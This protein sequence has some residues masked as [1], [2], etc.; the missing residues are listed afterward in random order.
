MKNMGDSMTSVHKAIR[1]LREFSQNEPELGISQLSR[2]LGI[3]KS[4]VS[5]L[6]HILCAENMVVQNPE[7]RKYHLSLTA[8]EIGSVVYNEMELCQIA[9]PMLKK[10]LSTVQAAIQMVTYDNGGIIYLVKLPEH[11]DGKIL[12]VMGKRVPAHCTA[13]GKVMLAFQDEHE[14]NRV[15]SHNLKAFTHKTIT[16]PDKLRLELQTIRKR[17]YAVSHD[18]FNQGMSSVAVPVFN[19]YDAIIASICILRP[20]GQITDANIPPLL[21]EMKMYSRL[22]TEQLGVGQTKKLRNLH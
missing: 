4:T 6:I 9:F 12:N 21:K 22:I 5:R 20:T 15:M 13:S 2:R 10:M 18:E 17:G 7:T 1:I 19:D 3:A 11:R 8:F 16:C 14:I